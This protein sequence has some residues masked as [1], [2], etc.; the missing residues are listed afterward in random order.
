MAYSSRLIRAAFGSVAILGSA[1]L[2]VTVMTNTFA[3]NFSAGGGQCKITN[4]SF[5]NSSNLVKG[6]RSK[7]GLPSAYVLLKRHMSAFSVRTPTYCAI[8]QTIK[9]RSRISI[10]RLERQA[11]LMVALPR[12]LMVALPRQLMV[13]LPRQLPELPLAILAIINR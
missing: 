13:A 1:V 7:K 9:I 11:P 12:Q 5:T 4:S 2:G 6:L 3:A 10:N 8:F